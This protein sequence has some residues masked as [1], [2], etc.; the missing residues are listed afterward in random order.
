MTADIVSLLM[1]AV[2]PVSAGVWHPPRQNPKSSIQIL[3]GCKQKQNR[4]FTGTALIYESNIQGVVVN[5][6][7]VFQ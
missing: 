3:K 7:N 6:K 1:I 2:L 5:S 4:G